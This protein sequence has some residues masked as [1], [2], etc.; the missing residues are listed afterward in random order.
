MKLMEYAM[1][2]MR[3]IDLKGSIEVDQRIQLVSININR[4]GS[5]LGN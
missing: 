3:S 4:T 1:P 5:E 2:K